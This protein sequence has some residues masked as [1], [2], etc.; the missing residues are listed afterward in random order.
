LQDS[1]KYKQILTRIKAGRHLSEQERVW[2][3]HYLSLSLAE[4]ASTRHKSLPALQP[5]PSHTEEL[6][7]RSRALVERSKELRRLN[8]KLVSENEALTK[9]ISARILK[10]KS[11]TAGK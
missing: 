6:L 5:F 4:R 1:L 3:N 10:V 2:T 7:N 9:S 11:A 8:A